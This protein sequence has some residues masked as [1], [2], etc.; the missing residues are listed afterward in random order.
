MNIDSLEII[1]AVGI[2]AFR[3]G[4]SL[5]SLTATLENYTLQSKGSYIDLRWNDFTF[6]IE[7]ING[8]CSYISL[9]KNSRYKFA[10]SIGIGSTLADLKKLGYTYYEADEMFVP[11]QLVGHNGISF[12]INEEDDDD[13]DYDDTNFVY[14]E[15]KYP[16]EYI[17]VFTCFK[18]G[19]RVKKYTGYVEGREP[20]YIH[21]VVRKVFDNPREQYEVEFD[22]KVE[23]CLPYELRLVAAEE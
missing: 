2:G 7:K 11:Y 8:I 6:G 1:P 19:D 20:E 15:C 22:G 9:Q 23:T 17:T 4:V 3:L 12:Q 14:D 21:G 16:I 5:E 10:G 18:E 13:D